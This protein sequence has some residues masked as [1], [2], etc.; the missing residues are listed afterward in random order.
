MDA[1]HYEISVGYPAL[2]DFLR[3]IDS[4]NYAHSHLGPIAQY[5][6]G[7]I[8]LFFHNWN[9]SLSDTYFEAVGPAENSIAFLVLSN[10]HKLPYVSR[11]SDPR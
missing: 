2:P 3:F 1:G 6:D 10:R 7:G 5:T 11:S 9:C 8:E 4:R